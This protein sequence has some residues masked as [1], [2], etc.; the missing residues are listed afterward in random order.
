MPHRCRGG[1]NGEG[2][3]GI[4]VA[5]IGRT[6]SRERPDV[7]SG[8]REKLLNTSPSEIRLSADV[9]AA[10]RVGRTDGNR[11]PRDRIASLVAVADG[12][13]SLYFST[14]GGFI[15]G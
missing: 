5:S 10:A 6:M 11:L 12:T 13:T 3:A 2:G 9:R 14:G 15:G 4:E 7:F 8:L 1:A